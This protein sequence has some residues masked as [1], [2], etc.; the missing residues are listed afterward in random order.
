MTFFLL[1]LLAHVVADFALQADSVVESKGKRIPRGYL[2]HGAIVL[3][4]NAIAFHVYGLKVAAAIAAAVAATHIGIDWLKSMAEGRGAV[5]STR[6]GAGASGRSGTSS[7][8]I[9]DARSGF[10]GLDGRGATRGL[11]VFL[12]DQCAHVAVLVGVWELAVDLY[13]AR[14]SESVLRIY[15]GTFLRKT[16]QA[17]LP[18][19]TALDL[20]FDK[21]LIIALAYVTVVFVGAVFVRQVL[22]AFSIY[23][24]PR[25][26]TRA[27]RCIGM[28]E[29]ALMLTLVLVDALPS[30]AFVLTAKSLARFQELNDMGFAEYYLVGTLTSAVVAVSVGIA[31]RAVIQ[32]L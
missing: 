17:L 29:R 20:S 8:A 2:K 12:L 23:A 6:S 15:Q 7:G 30:I 11:L 22:D 28:A 27:G 16:V 26:S 4:S 19:C 13:V 25:L 1:G 14:L 32:V 3:V 18:A 5:G 21:V 24:E 31:A 10:D 9:G